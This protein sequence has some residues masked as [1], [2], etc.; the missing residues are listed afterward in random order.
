[1]EGRLALGCQAQGWKLRGQKGQRLKTAFELG[2]CVMSDE[3]DAAANCGRTT[4]P[5]G[6]RLP[7]WRKGSKT[8]A[9]HLLCRVRERPL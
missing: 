7:A 1:M 2:L 5:R 9:P 8:L 4:G 3:G 6:L